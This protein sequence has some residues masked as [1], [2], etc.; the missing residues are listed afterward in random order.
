M[1]DWRTPGNKYENNYFLQFLGLLSRSGI[2]NS[3]GAINYAQF[4][5]PGLQAL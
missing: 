3:T 4:N 5:W 2:T 1:H